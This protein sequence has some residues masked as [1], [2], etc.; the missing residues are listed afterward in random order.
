[1]V[2]YLNP[3][4]PDE[5]I[6]VTGEGVGTGAKRTLK[7]YGSDDFEDKTKK[8]F[9]FEV[10]LQEPEELEFTLGMN[11]R[12]P[13]AYLL[14][15][16]ELSGGNV[17]RA[18]KM[19]NVDRSVYYHRCAKIEGFKEKLHDIRER[20]LDFAE[21]KLWEHIDMGNL[22]ATMFY[23]RT[24]GKNRGYTTQVELVGD[25]DKP[26]EISINLGGGSNK[27]DEFEEYG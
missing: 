25:K 27:P 17:T 5:A 7:L 22:P 11:G 3:T 2:K 13:E 23:L 9:E 16:L 21:D 26:V 15:A 19:I 14:K 4:P 12:I 6:V 24:I 18:S 10:E 20:K 8:E 1:M